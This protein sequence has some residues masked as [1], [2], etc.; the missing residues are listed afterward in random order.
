[1]A[2]Q[3]TEIVQYV[4]D[5][6]LAA[7]TRAEMDQQ[8]TTAK[9]YP[10][11]LSKFMRECK[12]MV[13][14]N[15]EVADECIY[16]LPRGQKTIEGPSARLAEIVASAWGN[17]RAVARIVDEGAEFITA[18][19]VFHDLERNWSVGFEVRRRITD[20]KGNRYNAD[21]I[22]MT[23]NAA[24]A[25]AFRNVV[26]KGVPKAFW[27][28]AYELA[29]LIT[30]GSA[31][32]LVAKRDKALGYL[33]KMGVKLEAVLA[34]LCVAGVEDIGLD[35]I[36]TLRGVATGIKDGEMTIEEAFP[37]TRLE[38]GVPAP[39]SGVDGLKAS[40]NPDP[41]PSGGALAQDR[42]TGGNTDVT[43]ETAGAKAVAAEGKDA[44]PMD[45]TAGSDVQV[46]V[47]KPLDD[48]A[49]AN[50]RRSVGAALKRKGFDEGEL[51]QWLM[52]QTGREVVAL[53]QATDTELQS[54]AASLGVK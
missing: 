7:L 13:G 10:R 45:G 12:E 18:Q 50:L 15:P 1:M 26:F 6:M 11:S 34:S 29:R 23:G 40:M 52:D 21:M 4:P 48:I 25:I 47:V 44:P 43:D 51:L 8:I 14:L 37:G 46:A 3:E 5:T 28:P 32:T 49:R 35:H 16:A 36:T 31:E 2:L 33:Q 30:M 54:I 53:N 41:P 38:S 22:T 9:A 42:R 27:G 19:A 20:S 24:A 39:K 17:C